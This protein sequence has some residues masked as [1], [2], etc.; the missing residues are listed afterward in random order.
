MTSNLTSHH[1]DSEFISPSL[2]FEDFLEFPFF[3]KCILGL[4]GQSQKFPLCWRRHI[5]LLCQIKEFGNFSSNIVKCCQSQHFHLLHQRL[6]DLKTSL[7]GWW[8]LHAGQWQALEYIATSLKYI[9]MPCC[10][11]VC[12]I[13]ASTV[14]TSVCKTII[15]FSVAKTNNICT[16]LVSRWLCK[17]L[18]VNLEFIVQTLITTSYK[19]STLHLLHQMH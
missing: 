4:S 6:C 11:T 15:H 10:T 8:V 12:S 5:S 16:V 7:V 17:I 2:S 18:Y 14:C 9:G 13:A 19:H 3:S 1:H